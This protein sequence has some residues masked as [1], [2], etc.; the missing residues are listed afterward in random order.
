MDVWWFTVRT[1]AGRLNLDR[2]KIGE[3]ERTQSETCSTCAAE[4]YADSCWRQVY[5]ASNGS[6][7]SGS[8]A[9]L[10]SAAKS[11]KR[12][13]VLIGA[14]RLNLEADDI[15]IENDVLC[16]SFLNRLTKGTFET[17]DSDIAW[18]WLLA[19]SSGVVR[20]QDYKVGN[21]DLVAFGE[22][23]TTLT[24]FVDDRVWTK[25]LETATDGAAISGSKSEL[26]AAV[27]NGGDIRYILHVTDEIEGFGKSNTTL[28]QQADTLRWSGTDVSAMHVR[29][30]GVVSSH[31]E[32]DD[33][34]FIR[35]AY[36]CFSIVSTMGQVQVS[37]WFAGIHTSKGNSTNQVA[38]EW[39]VN[40]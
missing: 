20:K 12:V 27:Q 35:S 29:S 9:D 36:W 15:R 26:L 8:L 22:M 28:V 14:L 16:G 31:S 37:R 6:S 2:W 18:Q 19:C 38:I 21:T 7:V 32:L 11:G 4:W 3:H 13:R 10:L 1:S 23:N 24:W 40:Q 17:L 39:Y 33:I 25:V 5:Q 30:V 34:D